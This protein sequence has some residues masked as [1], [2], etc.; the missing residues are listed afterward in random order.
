MKPLCKDEKCVSYASA[1]VYVREG[2]QFGPGNIDA[3]AL[4]P[5]NGGTVRAVYDKPNIDNPIRGVDT[6]LRT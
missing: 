6:L 3:F 1:Y 5:V 2:N 4:L